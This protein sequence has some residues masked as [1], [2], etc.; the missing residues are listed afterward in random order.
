MG[1]GMSKEKLKAQRTK[2]RLS[3]EALARR[4]SISANT[5]YRW[6][7]GRSPIS[8]AMAFALAAVLDSPASPAEKEANNVPRKSNR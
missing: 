4:L 2:A 1:M 6:E 5:I 8:P 3:R 7:T